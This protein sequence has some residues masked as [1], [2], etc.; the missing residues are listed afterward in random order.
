[1]LLAGGL[2][3]S[4]SRIRVAS[5]DTGVI[6]A[7]QRLKQVREQLQ[8]TTREVEDASRILAEQR[9]NDEFA[10][11]ISRLSE[12]ENKGIVPSVYK[13]YA[14]CVIY[15]LDP[16]DV[17]AWYGVDVAS[18]AGD[19]I[20][21]EHEATHLLRFKPN[22]R[23]EVQ[24]PLKLDPGVDL[25]KTTF[26]SRVVQSWGSVPLALLRGFEPADYR[27]GFV[28]SEDWTMYPVL[29]PGSLVIIDTTRRKIATEGWTNEFDRPIYFLEHDD[30]WAC[31]W[32]SLQERQLV[33]LAHPA[34]PAAAQI[35][36]FP[37]GVEV[38]G[39]VTGVAMRLGQGRAPHKR[40]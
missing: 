33:V 39:Q 17:L 24:L 35:F 3:E 28:G 37:G 26:L 11:P 19:S 13:I 29:Q 40:P 10:I 2:L 14:L 38:V 27:Y 22:G 18:V 30:G 9:R 7:G 36:H 31:G 4:R 8:L 23:G 21:V 5:W 16:G 20:M 1:M 6:D 34:S 32:C 12:I 15:R 25:T